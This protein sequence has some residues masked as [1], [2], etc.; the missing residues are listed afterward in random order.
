MEGGITGVTK[1]PVQSLV[2]V[3][4]GVH[5]WLSKQLL[6]GSTFDVCVTVGVIVGVI[7]GVGDLV[8][9]GVAVLVGVGDNPKV[10]VGVWVIVSVGVGVG[11]SGGAIEQV[12]QLLLLIKLIIA[13]LGCGPNPREKLIPTP[14]TR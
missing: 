14:L 9:V 13:C 3:G 1:I 12:K 5:G 7:V 10:G 11:V 4:V 6:H 8:L 2:G